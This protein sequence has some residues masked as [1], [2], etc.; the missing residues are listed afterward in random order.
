[1]V[2]FGAATEQAQS[3]HQHYLE[4]DVE[5]EDI[6]GGKGTAHTGQQAVHQWNLHGKAPAAAGGGVAR[7]KDQTD[8]ADERGNQQHE[9]AEAVDAEADAIRLR[10]DAES[11]LQGR[12]VCDQIQQ[13]GRTNQRCVGAQQT[14]AALQRFARG[15]G[16]GQCGCDQRQENRRNDQKVHGLGVFFL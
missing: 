15:E 3:R 8:Q 5:V 2:Q 1:M 4:P 16:C 13:I 7:Q 12:P 11:S 6:G 14:D 9:G 10:P